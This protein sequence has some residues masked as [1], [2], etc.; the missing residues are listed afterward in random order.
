MGAPSQGSGGHYEKN[1]AGTRSSWL[2][3][4]LAQCHLA[5]CAGDNPQPT[6]KMCP[7]TYIPIDELQAY[8]KNA[9]T[10]RRTDQQVRDVDIGK[11]N[12]AIGIVHRGKLDIPTPNSVAEHDLVSE[13]YHV[14]DGSGT[15]ELIWIWLKDKRQSLGT[16]SDAEACEK[17][18]TNTI[19]FLLSRSLLIQL[20][21]NPQCD[22]L[23]A[24]GPCGD[25]CDDR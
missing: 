1:D 24:Q 3:G 17:R 10:E 14:I 22:R 2:P 18:C 21:Y 15:L 20:S 7:G 13:V 19:R 23:R 12:V 11:A 25:N 16:F 5:Q 9:I 4:H 6:C 8:L